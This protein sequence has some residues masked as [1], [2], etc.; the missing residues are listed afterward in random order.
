MAVISAAVAAIRRQACRCAARA[1]SIIVIA[2]LMLPPAM[3]TP[4][5]A[6][7]VP[8]A[9]TGNFFGDLMGLFGAKPKP[10][11]RASST[12]IIVPGYGARRHTT[13]PAD[14]QPLGRGG[15]AATFGGAPEAPAAS[16]P[17]HQAKY[18]AMCVRLCDGYYWPISEAAPM[19]EF[20]QANRV[21]EQSCGSPAKLYYQ[22][23]KGEDPGRMMGLDG[24]PYISL[25]TAFLYRKELKPECRCKADP[26]SMTER[27]RHQSYASTQFEG[28][29]QAEATAGPEVTTLQDEPPQAFAAPEASGAAEALDAS[30]DQQD[31][32]TPSDATIEKAWAD[33]L[34]TRIEANGVVESTIV[35]TL[36]AGE[37][38]DD[39]TFSP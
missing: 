29:D 25:D 36:R 10:K 14:M 33:T 39:Y 32:A 24:K 22:S 28:S 30:A 2:A 15:S 26:W 31:A 11:P 38:E 7:M 18:R 35:Q 34:N 23:D 1:C 27:M 37:T 6:Q 12:A 5:L 16:R 20:G 9:G 4:A 17:S 8:A 19:S 3:E 21:C 13:R